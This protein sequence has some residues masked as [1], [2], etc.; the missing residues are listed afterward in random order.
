MK[1]TLLV[2]MTVC[3]LSSVGCAAKMKK[4]PADIVPLTTEQ[5]AEEK[6][7]GQ[8]LKQEIKDSELR[9]EQI[10]KENELEKA[11]ISTLTPEQLHEEVYKVLSS[12]VA[13]ATISIEVFFSP[14]DNCEKPWIDTI[15]KTSSYVYVSCF[16]ITNQNITKALCDQSKKGIKVIVCTDKMQAGNKTAKIREQELKTAGAEYI[17]K[18]KQVLEHNKMVVVDDKYAIIGSWNLSGN[19]QPQD[20]SI[21]LF[22]Y[23]Y[24]AGK[25]RQAIERIYIRDK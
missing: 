9:I 15:M 10:N 3:L 22:N 13:T 7:V 18:K 16:G 4:N 11:R 23:P 6:I 21:V 2:V 12:T 8:D 1:K 25:V 24:I 19:A 5:R 20:N 17:I 14:Y